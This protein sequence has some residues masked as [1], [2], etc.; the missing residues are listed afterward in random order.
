MDLDHY[1][2]FVRAGFRKEENSSP[3][4]SSQLL[5]HLRLLKFISLR[6]PY[7]NDKFLCLPT[8]LSGLK[9]IKKA[10]KYSQ[11]FVKTSLFQQL[12]FG[13]RMFY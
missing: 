1:P 10:Q 11:I 5:F 2:S 4:T 6:P 13:K 3:V 9:N 12:P 7:P 8:Y